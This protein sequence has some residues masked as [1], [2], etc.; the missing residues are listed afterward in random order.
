MDTSALT[1]L[2]DEI[3]SANQSRANEVCTQAAE[4][5]NFCSANAQYF[6]G[7]GVFSTLLFQ[8]I[9]IFVFGCLASLIC[10]CVTEHASNK[11]KLVA[12]RLRSLYMPTFKAL[13]F[14]CIITLGAIL[15]RVFQKPSFFELAILRDIT[16]YE[17]S[18]VLVA[19]VAYMIHRCLGL[20]YYQD[21]EKEEDNDGKMYLCSSIEFLIRSVI[22][23]K[24]QGSLSGGNVMQKILDSCTNLA[25]FADLPTTVKAPTPS[26]RTPLGGGWMVFFTVFGIL[27]FIFGPLILTLIGLWPFDSGCL[28]ARVTRISAGSILVIML[29][30]VSSFDLFTVLQTRSALVGKCTSTTMKQ[31]GPFQVAVL[32]IWLPLILRISLVVLSLIPSV[33]LGRVTDVLLAFLYGDDIYS[34]RDPSCKVRNAA[35]SSNADVE[36]DPATES[37]EDA[38]FL[39]RKA[40]LRRASVTRSN[41]YPSSNSEKRRNQSSVAAAVAAAHNY[42]NGNH[43]TTS[44]Q[45]TRPEL[46]GGIK[47]DPFKTV[48]EEMKHLTGNIEQ[49]LGSGHPMLETVAKYYTKSEGKHIRP[50]LV[51]LISQ[52]TAAVTVTQSPPQSLSPSAIDQPL[53]PPHILQ[54]LNPSFDTP[55]GANDTASSYSTHKILP[56]QNRLAEITELIHTASLLHDDVLD[57][58]S[59]RRS[60]PSA[61]MAFGNKMAVLAGDFLL[62]RASVALARLRSSEVTELLATV[63]ANLIEGEFMQLRNT[64]HDEANPTFSDQETISYYLHKTYLKSASLMSKSCR[65][66]AILGGCRRDIVDAAYSYGRNLGLAFQLVDDMLDFT[67]P[68]S[69]TQLGKPAGADLQLGLATAPLLFAWKSRPE[70]GPLVGRKFDLEGDVEKAREIVMTSDG[71]E[72]TRALAQSFA[73]RARGAIATW[74]DCEAKTGLLEMCERVMK[75]KK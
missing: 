10:A 1:G 36:K 48:A 39:K 51:L 58:S 25:R 15:I 22:T 54:D 64:S 71:I 73:D 56:A 43:S 31:W 52:A 72:Q 32:L 34:I 28:K 70:L 75:R 21:N 27:F 55:T 62:G 44:L 65:A 50:M 35:N 14:L 49:L 37:V 66:A 40:H 42:L 16:E 12:Y 60:M 7:V 4:Q 26:L 53:T 41:A 24:I 17:A 20:P 69:S 9:F 5:S 57:T 6:A 11:A 63:I 47:I 33:T 29:G 46:P 13:Y 68:S 3:S 74:P 59:T 2:L 18:L 38:P 45:P 8:G 61:N 23:L 19:G 67:A 30:L